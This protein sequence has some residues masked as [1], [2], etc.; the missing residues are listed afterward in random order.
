MGHRRVARLSPPA[1]APD[2]ICCRPILLS[3]ETV[4]RLTHL[5][6]SG[7]PGHVSTIPK[8]MLHGGG[9]EFGDAQIMLLLLLLMML[10]LLLR[11]LLLLLNRAT[12]SRS[13][14]Q[15]AKFV[16]IARV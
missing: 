16:W 5:G 7:V 6:S 2:L 10:L 14:H 15:C 12:P 3:S 4:D 8:L 13:H 1:R 11:L 9:G